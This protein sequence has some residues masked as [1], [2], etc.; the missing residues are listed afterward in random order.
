MLLPLVMIYNSFLSVCNFCGFGKFF[1]ISKLRQT[2][3]PPTTIIFY[4]LYHIL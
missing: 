2:F 3:T 1:D 4:F